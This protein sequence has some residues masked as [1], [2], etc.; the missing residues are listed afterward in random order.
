VSAACCHAVVCCAA[1][2]LLEAS[3]SDMMRWSVNG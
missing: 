1:R 2:P 3:D